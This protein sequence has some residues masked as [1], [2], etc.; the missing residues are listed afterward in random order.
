MVHFT[1]NQ[2]V[3]KASL[4]RAYFIVDFNKR[5]VCPSLSEFDAEAAYRMVRFINHRK[6]KDRIP[7][8]IEA[9]DLIPNPLPPFAPVR[10]FQ[11]LPPEGRLPIEE[12]ERGSLD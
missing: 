12:V 9:E 6:F 2:K 8:Y 5:A 4:V 10:S 11:L 3:A 7:W 1:C